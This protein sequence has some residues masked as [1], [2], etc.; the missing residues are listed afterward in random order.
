MT[1]S[2]SKKI[3]LTS[4]A[5]LN[6][7]LHVGPIRPDGYH[8]LHTVYQALDI[9]DEI[10]VTLLENGTAE[11][12][13]S[14]FPDDIDPKTN[15]VRRAWQ[16]CREAFPG[17]IPSVHINAQKRLPRGGG[18]GGGS[19]NAA[20]V[21]KALASLCHLGDIN[22]PAILE[23]LQD[24]AARI[25]SDVPFFIRRGVAQGTGRGEIITPLTDSRKFW[26]VLLLPD[27][28]VSTA[29]AYRTLDEHPRPVLNES[30]WQMKITQLQSALS[31]GNANLLA[32]LIQND[33]DLF[34][35]QYDWF[36]KSLSRLKRE[37]CLRA[38]LCGSGSTVA[39]LFKDEASAREA[40]RATG[41]V[42]AS[43]T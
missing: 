28:S 20:T 37:S 1:L 35:A 39:G 8:S 36:Q 27:A 7:L 13:L 43:T 10:T 19:S 6:W 3:T 25:G 5:K 17:R 38:F 21:I 34:A 16:A 23:K 42:L 11:C 14:S 18:L 41:G 31:D 2:N 12:I 4:P 9:A 29:E 15:L 40:A 26:L 33:F 30:D 22:D 32:T 24:V